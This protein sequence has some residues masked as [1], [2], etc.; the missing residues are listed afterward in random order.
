MILIS[1]INT[2]NRLPVRFS[3]SDLSCISLW[4][5]WLGFVGYFCV[6]LISQRSFCFTLTCIKIQL[7]IIF[8]RHF[9][10]SRVLY[11]TFWIS[12]VFTFCIVLLSVSC[13]LVS[14][15]ISN[16]ITQRG[17]TYY[18]VQI[19]NRISFSNSS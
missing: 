14:C 4:C 17:K 12:L 5:L 15:R 11:V 7:I 18:A 3:F 19:R 13:Q 1:L 2:F 9:L 10:Y 16:A 8:V 6:E